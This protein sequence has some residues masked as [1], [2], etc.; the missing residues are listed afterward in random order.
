MTLPDP[1]S[2]VARA[3]D[4]DTD[5]AA[6]AAPNVVVTDR[7]DADAVE[8]TDEGYRGET[9][10][11]LG[12]LAA[13]LA[14]GDAAV[15]YPEPDLTAEG[16]W[17]VLAPLSGFVATVA[18]GIGRTVVDVDYDPRAD[19]GLHAVDDRVSALLDAA[20]PTHDHY[21]VAEDDAGVFTTGM[22]TFAL[23]SLTVEDAL[24][25]TFDVSTT[26]ATRASDVRARFADVPGVEAVT[27]ESVAGVERADPSPTLR[28]AVEDAH[29]E[30]VGDCQYDW[31]P[32]PGVFGEILG[33][34]KVAFGTGEPDA[35]AYSRE[36]YERCV[37]LLESVVSSAEVVA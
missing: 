19:T 3:R 29:R 16:P 4:T 12:R 24:T 30:V 9:A 13:A 34:E 17:L 32:E 5:S 20:R 15:H 6:A 31:L 23:D 21:P 27:Y 8:R 28:R 35:T 2:V 7:V 22:T 25:A 33:G 18:K 26:P 14:V 10:G 1:E 11:V 36:Q 37:E